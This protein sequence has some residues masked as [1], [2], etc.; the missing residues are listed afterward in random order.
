MT[1]K[2]KISAPFIDSSFINKPTDIA[3]YFNDF[4]IGKTSKR[5]HDMSVTNPDITHPSISD[6]FMNCNLNSVR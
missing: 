6:Q 3:N 1:F 5:R 4:S 2:K